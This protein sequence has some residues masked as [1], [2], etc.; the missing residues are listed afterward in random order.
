MFCG[1][2]PEEVSVALE[3]LSAKQKSRQYSA[4]NVSTD[5]LSSVSAT[6]CSE[7]LGADSEHMAGQPSKPKRVQS[8]RLRSRQSLATA[9]RRRETSQVELGD[10]EEDFDPR[11][12]PKRIHTLQHQLRR[13]SE[14][15]IPAE[16][17]EESVSKRAGHR[18]ARQ[19]SVDRVNYLDH[20]RTMIEESR[21]LL[22]QSKAKHHALVAQAHSMQK[23]LRGQRTSSVPLVELSESQTAL[24]PRPPADRKPT[25]TFRTHRL[26]RYFA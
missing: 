23:R 14:V 7:P 13:S 21:A 8:A 1:A 15:N 18:V 19:S 26:A 9:G 11:P 10:C 6:H 12:N 4:T 17:C 22:E 16:D 20:Q 2:G 24:A 3:R 5:V 25:S